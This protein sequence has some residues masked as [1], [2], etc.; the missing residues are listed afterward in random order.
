VC[1]WPE[2]TAMLNLIACLLVDEVKY[3]FALLVIIEY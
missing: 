1:V 2:Y 3:F